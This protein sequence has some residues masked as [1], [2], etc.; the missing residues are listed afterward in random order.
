MPHKTAAELFPRYSPNII[1]FAHPVVREW[2]ELAW[3]PHADRVHSSQALAV[4]V[5][6]TLQLAPDR[7]QVLTAWA[8]T[9]QLPAAGPWSVQLEFKDP[10][11]LL[12]ERQPTM[13]DVCLRNPQLLLFVECKFTEAD[14]GA[15][16]QTQPSKKSPPPCNGNYTFQTHAQSPA[17]ARCALTAKAIRYWEVI[18]TI[19]TYAAHTDYTPCPFAGPA[20]Q[21]MRNMVIAFRLAQHEQR[22]AAFVVLSVAHPRLPM[23]RKNWEP[24]TRTLRPGVLAF[25]TTTFQDLLAVARQAGTEPTRWQTLQQWVEN[26]ITRWLTRPQ[27]TDRSG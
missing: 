8:E 3:H 16:T 24:F 6:G 27:K 20:Y 26:K 17:P 7:D 15:C 13:V 4:D 25:R 10:L 21:W 5:F 1:P 14:G 19:F 11:N 23:A 22:Q 9:L 12:N 2:D 18:P